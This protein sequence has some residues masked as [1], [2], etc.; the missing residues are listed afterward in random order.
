MKTVYLLTIGGYVCLLW[1]TGIYVT[2]KSRSSEAYLVASRGLS[3]PF[4]SVLIAGTWIG[5]LAG[6]LQLIFCLIL[7]CLCQ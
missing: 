6:I 1:L 5:G 4:I 2:R 7:I 3:T